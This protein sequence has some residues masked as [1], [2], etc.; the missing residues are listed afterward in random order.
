MLV[1]TRKEGET[2]V[3]KGPSGDA[4]TIRITIARLN[5]NSVRVAID[6]QADVDILR[7]EL[8]QDGE[9]G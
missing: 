7:G 2:I 4:G 6:A 8:L 9:K 1:L 5:S 3:L